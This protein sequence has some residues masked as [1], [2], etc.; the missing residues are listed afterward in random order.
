[1]F[2]MRPLSDGFMITAILGLVISVFY[3][4]SERIPLS[5]GIAFILA[6]LAMFL[7]SVLSIT[8]RFPESLK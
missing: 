6:F 7:A 3:T 2:K 1:M 8:P 4:G 5:W